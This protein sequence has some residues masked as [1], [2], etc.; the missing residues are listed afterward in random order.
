[1]KENYSILLPFQPR[2]YSRNQVTGS[3]PVFINN[4]T[5]SCLMSE[6]CWEMFMQCKTVCICAAR[7]LVK[8][9]TQTTSRTSL[10][11]YS[12]YS[13]TYKAAGQQKS[14]SL[15]QN[16]CVWYE[17]RFRKI[18]MTYN[19]TVQRS[20]LDY[21]TL[22]LKLITVRGGCVTMESLKNLFT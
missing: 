6:R 10:F 16:L 22:L 13:S 19:A 12:R 2:I 14:C 7:S 18:W 9:Q 17:V 4:K 15:R 1:M 20:K 8:H 11:N 3:R 21:D 5:S